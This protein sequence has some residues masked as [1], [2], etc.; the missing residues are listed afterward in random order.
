MQVPIPELG[1]RA[2][3]LQ[4]KLFFRMLL[5]GA[6]ALALMQGGRFVL[7]GERDAARLL[8]ALGA[9]TALLAVFCLLTWVYCRIPLRLA[10]QRGKALIRGYNLRDQRRARRHASIRTELEQAIPY[11][12]VLHSEIVAILEA[13]DRGV[14]ALVERL[15]AVLQAARTGVSQVI[16]SVQ[17]AVRAEDLAC[18]HLEMQAPESRPGQQVVP[19][20]AGILQG[21]IGVQAMQEQLRCSSS[22]LIEASRRLDTMHACIIQELSDA[23]ERIQLQDVLR[24]RLAEVDGALAEMDEHLNDLVAMMLNPTWDGHV[25][26]GLA[27][28]LRLRSRHYVMHA[29]RVSAARQMGEAPPANDS[30]EVELF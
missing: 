24:Q 28:R 19:A 27:Q 26:N 2:R 1:R 25:S 18:R 11:M 30:T 29:Q 16:L 4:R 23:V 8:S 15:D 21:V 22:G 14:L 17:S 3:R 5:A 12:T 10:L 20:P 7:S 6:C 13:G 9:D